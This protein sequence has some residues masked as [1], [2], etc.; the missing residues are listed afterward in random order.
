MLNADPVSTKGTSTFIP[1]PT[2]HVTSRMDLV[3]SLT[4]TVKS[5]ESEVVQMQQEAGRGFADLGSLSLQWLV[6]SPLA[7]QLTYSVPVQHRLSIEVFMTKIYSAP[8]ATV[9]EEWGPYSSD[10]FPNY[11]LS[12][13]Y[14]TSVDPSSL[15]AIRK[16]LLFQYL[17]PGGKLIY[18][19]LCENKWRLSLVIAHTSLC[20]VQIRQ[21]SMDC[22]LWWWA[23]I[24]RVVV[25]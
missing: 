21:N 3:P 12:W 9:S 13:K 2:L 16:S 6:W 22:C 15:T 25:E 8:D 5:W 11:L 20:E 4:G 23:M 19:L 1:E 10:G 7:G 24:E 14:L 17:C 18:G